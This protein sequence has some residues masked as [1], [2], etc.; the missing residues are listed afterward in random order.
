M[1]TNQW[2]CYSWAL[3]INELQFQQ[4]FPF[5]TYSDIIQP[6]TLS[7]APIYI[8]LPVIERQSAYLIAFEQQGLLIP[9]LGKWQWLWWRHSPK[10]Q[11]QMF[12]DIS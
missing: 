11:W 3:S 1:D 9:G 7:E 4:Y 6:H 5:E 10:S 8:F 12:I 2:S